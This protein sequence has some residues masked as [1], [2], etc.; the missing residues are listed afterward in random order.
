MAELWGSV[1][2]SLLFWGFANQVRISRSAT[3]SPQTV[4]STIAELPKPGHLWIS[5]PVASSFSWLSKFTLMY[6][7]GA[8][9]YLV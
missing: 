7:L 1:V 8:I 3:E 6:Q 4:P 2:V 9:D 5:I